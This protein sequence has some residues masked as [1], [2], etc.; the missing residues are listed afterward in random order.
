MGTRGCGMNTSPMHVVVINRSM[1]RMVCS[2]IVISRRVGRGRSDSNIAIAL[3]SSVFFL[4]SKFFSFIATHP[5]RTRLLSAKNERQ[6]FLAAL[7]SS[8]QSSVEEHNSPPEQP[9][10]MWLWLSIERL[11]FH[12]ERD[13]QR[14][15]ST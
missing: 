4:S 2:S 15:R 14:P 1:I 10:R 8:M 13:R 6:C 3:F 11:Y 5:H 7:R 9:I 12:K